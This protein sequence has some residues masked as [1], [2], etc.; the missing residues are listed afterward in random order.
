MPLDHRNGFGYFFLAGG[1]LGLAGGLEQIFRQVALW[2]RAV[3]VEAEVISVRA[4]TWI[5]DNGAQKTVH[6]PTVS[7]TALGA[8]VRAEVV[9]GRSD[10][11]AF[12]RGRR[13]VVYYDPRNPRSVALRRLDWPG[14][15]AA[16]LLASLSTAIGLALL[17]A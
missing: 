3:R 8:R 16:T 15:I 13:L 2:R 6:L 14:G 1:L 7:F 4:E 10:P 11:R 17:L 9:Q 5:E 12:R